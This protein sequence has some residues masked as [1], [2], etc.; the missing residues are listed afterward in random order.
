[1]FT[2]RD[3]P[4][5]SNCGHSMHK[6]C[7]NAYVKN[8]YRC[9]LCYKSL[10]DMSHTWEYYDQIIT[11]DVLPSDFD[12]AKAQILCNDCEKKTEAKWHIHGIKC[13][14]CGSYN[15]KILA[16]SGFPTG[17]TN[18]P[19]PPTENSDSNPPPSNP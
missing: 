6:K 14:E 2:S 19:T 16:T 18:Y 1:M 17:N 8:N 9:P 3:P 11:E 12:N 13:S 4:I 7:Y 15:T 5:T 10:G